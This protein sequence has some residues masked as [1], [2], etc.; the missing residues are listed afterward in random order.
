MRNNKKAGLLALVLV[1]YLLFG[2]SKDH[3]QELAQS[4]GPL[5]KRTMGLQQQPVKETILSEEN[6]APKEKGAQVIFERKGE[7]FSAKMGS[8]ITTTGKKKK[9]ILEF[10]KASL[11]DVIHQVMGNLLGLNYIIDPSVKGVVSL[12]LA[13]EFDANTLLLALQNVLELNGFTMYKEGHTYKIVYSKIAPSLATPMEKGLL[14]QVYAPKYLKPSELF[15][16]LAPVMSSSGKLKP[17]NGPRLLLIVDKEPWV[18]KAMM[19]LKIVDVDSLARFNLKVV[20]LLY[21]DAYDTAKETKDILAGMGMEEKRSNFFILPVER[22]NYLILGSPSQDLMEEI[23]EI[24]KVLD[25]PPEEQRRKVYIYKVQHVKAKDLAEVVEAFFSNKGTINIEKRREKQPSPFKEKGAAHSSAGLLTRGI[26]IVPD[27]TTNTLLIESSADD[28]LKVKQILTALDA[29]PRQVLIEVLIAE[30]TLDKGLEHGVEWWL[31]SGGGHYKSTTAVQYGLAGS[32]STLFGFTYY[33]INPDRFW[34]FVYLLSTRSK[35]EIL[36]SPH[37]MARDN[38][39]AKIDVGKEIPVITT[40]TVGATEIQGT[41]AIDRRIEYKDVG[42]ILTV[43]PHISENG[44]VSMDV[45]QEV[46]DA[47]ENTVSGIDSPVILKRR[48]ESSLMVQNGHAIVMGGIIQHNKN[49]V[50]KSVPVLGSIPLLGKL[51]SYEKQASTKTELIVMITPYVLKDIEDADL[52]TRAF[53]EKLQNLKKKM[54]INSPSPKAP[55]K[56][57]TK[58]ETPP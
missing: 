34:N 27:E 52:I 15:S 17:L 43:T 13:G 21:S 19:L 54:G 56:E 58:E 49:L 44:F 10:D 47:E 45:V 53:Q 16:V 1:P 39:E 7:T 33:G 24:L 8:P 30:V 40:E 12:R 32:Q 55:D 2:C 11:V 25:A 26:R 3:R 9:V 38:E 51:F 35:L 14:F 31:K 50:K 29:M 37:I 4:M 46:S 22:L 23:T 5:S 42:V 36:S 28:Y 18:N 41:A 57:K 20:R 6:H 48:A